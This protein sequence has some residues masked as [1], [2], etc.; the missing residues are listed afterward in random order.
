MLCSVAMFPDS[1]LADSAARKG[2]PTAK[3]A[4]TPKPS[5]PQYRRSYVVFDDKLVVPWHKGE[6]HEL[7]WKISKAWKVVLSAPGLKPGNTTGYQDRYKVVSSSTGHVAFQ[8]KDGLNPE[9]IVFTPI[10]TYD[11]FG[12]DDVVESVTLYD[13]PKD[14]GRTYTKTHRVARVASTPAPT[15]SPKPDPTPKPTPTIEPAPKPAPTASPSSLPQLP[16]LTDPSTLKL[17]ARVDQELYA[18]KE[19][20]TLTSYGGKLVVNGPLNQI[21]PHQGLF[22]TGQLLLA[23]VPAS[24]G[25]SML[26]LSDKGI[27]G[28]QPTIGGGYQLTLP[29]QTHRG[30]ARVGASLRTEIWKDPPPFYPSW[31]SANL[32]YEGSIRKEFLFVKGWRPF[33]DVSFN[34][35]PSWRAGVRWL[36]VAE[37]GYEVGSG[38]YGHGR[39]HTDGRLVTQAVLELLG[40]HVG[41]V[42]YSLGIGH[43]PIPGAATTAN[44]SLG[45]EPFAK[46]IGE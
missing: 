37:D 5:A 29:D 43:N 17:E 12:D 18:T 16:V 45:F 22:W 19:G 9:D 42:T 8:L 4:P 1:A 33:A 24:N 35:L 41:P 38:V 46:R 20:G 11:V 7:S 44:V 36:Y 6:Q 10:N 25:L 14:D 3:T 2:A 13:S 40:G 39:A 26:V 30:T 28:I 21:D 23:T 31:F 27:L 15:A 32:G 34:D